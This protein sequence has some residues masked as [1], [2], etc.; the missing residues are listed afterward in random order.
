MQH[1]FEMIHSLDLGQY[2][3]M[4]VARR[5][6]G[7]G[8]YQVLS[9]ALFLYQLTH[10]LWSLDFVLFIGAFMMAYNKERQ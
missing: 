3:G 1:V 8:D 5:M 9:T 2:A 10:R 6:P 7:M 4:L